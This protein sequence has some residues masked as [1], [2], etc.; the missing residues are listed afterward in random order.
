MQETELMI[1]PMPATLAA[2]QSAAVPVGFVEASTSPESS[3]A[4]HRGPAAHETPSIP[5]LA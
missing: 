4:T 3:I 2:L 5:S 1:E